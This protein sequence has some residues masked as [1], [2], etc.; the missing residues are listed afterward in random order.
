[1]SRLQ[2]LANVGNGVRRREERA[3]QPPTTLADELRKCLWH[4]SLRDS[5]LDV[6]QDP[7]GGVSGSPIPDGRYRLNDPPVGVPLRDKLET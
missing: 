4:I 7:V 6:L 5:A 3:I 1:M 2:D